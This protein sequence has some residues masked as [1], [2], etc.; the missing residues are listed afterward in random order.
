MNGQEEK[1]RQLIDDGLRSIWF[2]FTQM[3]EFSPE[4][5]LVIAEGKGT[6]LR[7]VDGRDYIDGVSSLWTN[8]HGHRKEQI[9]RAVKEQVDRLSH[10]TLLGL[11]HEPAIECAKKLLEVVP[12]GLTRVFYSESG[13]TAVEIALKMAFQYQKQAAGGNPDKTR[14]ISF[15]NAYHGDTLGAVSVGGID[16]FHAVYH[17]LLFPTVKAESPYCYRCPFGASQP[18]CQF[19][20]LKQ[21]E[22]LLA[23][24]ASELAALIIEPLVQ[25][26][27]GILVQ[28]PGYLR[29]VRDLC[30]QYGVLMIADEVAVG[31]GK[32][33]TMFA[34]QQ[35]GVTPD[36][37]AVGKGLS[38]GY[39][40]LAATVATEEI[41]SGFLG[42]FDEFKTFFHGHTYTGN[43]LACAAAVASLN[44]FTEERVVEGLAGKI[45][46]FSQGLQPIAKLGHVGE[47]RQR[48]FMVGIEL[49]ADKKTKELY[50]PGARI[51]HRVILEARKRGLI[52]RPL[53]DVIVLMPP[54]CITNE[55]I[56]RLCE[57]TL[58]SIRA[59][60]GD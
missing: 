29:R 37:M 15:T 7:D 60:V 13:S 31:F 43:P 35:E 1:K 21:L 26:A 49:V 22:N 58:D 23:T 44:I 17:E 2:P 30:T 56:D 9:D 12:K 50:P 53:G 18:S 38:G 27:G 24:H 46:R 8:V 40:P 52:I 34:C 59:V 54:L 45:K 42:R 32:T 3:R 6:L 57:I 47:I 39:L 48:G 20:C 36:I 41:Y 5:V 4:D 28:P 55:E 51:G 10:S 25:G 11:V 19:D 14:F 33:G 16:L